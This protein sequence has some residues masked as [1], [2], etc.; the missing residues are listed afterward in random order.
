MMNKTQPEDLIEFP[1][2]YQFKAVGQ[3]DEIFQDAIIAAISRHVSVARDAVH[4][5]PSGKGNYLA[6]SVLVTLH[7]YQQ[8]TSIYTEMRKVEGLKLLL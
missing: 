4:S 1:C 7:N 5:R 8:L 3:A 6:V 2:Q